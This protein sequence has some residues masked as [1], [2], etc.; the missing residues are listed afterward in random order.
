M[1]VSNELG[2]SHPRTAKFSVGMAV[3]SSSTLGLA[4]SI[5]LV[6]LRKVYP[7]LFSNDSSVK[8]L[9]EDLTPLL[10]ICIFINSIQP[11]LS[12]NLVVFAFGF[13]SLFNPPPE[14]EL[15]NI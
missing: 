3:M 8:D 4:I 9:V 11:V 15:L 6:A 14:R 7:S 5:V 13:L 2:A 12:G 10:A 1:R